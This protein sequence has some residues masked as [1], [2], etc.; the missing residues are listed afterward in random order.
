M[1]FVVVNDIATVASVMPQTLNAEH[2]VVLKRE[3]SASRSKVTFRPHMV[4]LAFRWLM[5]NNVTYYDEVKKLPQEQL[6]EGSPLV[7]EYTNG[8]VPISERDEEHL[9]A[10]AH[11]AAANPTIH[12]LGGQ[13]VLLMSHEPLDS[14]EESVKGNLAPSL[15]LRR[16]SGFVTPQTR[17][18]FFEKAFP[19][20]YPYGRGGQQSYRGGDSSGPVQDHAL[21]EDQMSKLLL[22]RGGDR[23]F[24]LSMAFLFTVYSFFMKKRSGTVSLLAAEAADGW[25]ATRSDSAEA[26][27]DVGTVNRRDALSE[28]RACPSAE[29]M[30]DALTGKN[31]QLFNQL[32]SRFQPFAKIMP[33]TA[34]HIASEKRGLMAMMRDTDVR[35]NAELRVFNTISPADR[36]AVSFFFLH[37]LPTRVL[38]A[39][40]CVRRANIPFFVPRPAPRLQPLARI[41]RGARTCR[42]RRSP[43]PSGPA[44]R[45]A[46]E[47]LRAC[48]KDRARAHRVDA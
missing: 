34:P 39:R 4:H 31:A 15:T 47:T 25:A 37:A 9:D 6:P 43:A 19:G 36:Y 30:V 20:L 10:A 41:V 2:L 24:S 1:S 29:D 28:I 42:T 38:H 7:E 17:Q 23:R 27:V 12:S 21:K 11:A 8:C 14:L 40:T 44:N 48:H 3:G 18:R 33:G 46:A 45:A 32:L 16:L 13:D 5:R 35:R 26:A 22:Q